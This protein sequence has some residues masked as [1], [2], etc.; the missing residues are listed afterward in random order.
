[1][2]TLNIRKAASTFTHWGRN[3]KPGQNHSVK[4]PRSTSAT[5][6][7]KQ[8][9]ICE[10]ASTDTWEQVW[11]H[12]H[13][14]ARSPLSYLPTST[15]SAADPGCPKSSLM[16]SVWACPSPVYLVS[17]V[18][19]AHTGGVG[20]LTS[21]TDRQSCSWPASKRATATSTLRPA[22]KPAFC[23]TAV[24]AYTGLTTLH[25]ARNSGDTTVAFTRQ[26]PSSCTI[27]APHSQRY[28]Q[29]PKPC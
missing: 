10:H 8:Q 14:Q 2:F 20:S 13:L 23:A 24:P 3:R 18:A 12:S 22:T 1:M 27:A 16:W 4:S 29:S 9:A 15:C 26:I 25:N 19:L 5:D 28:W 6:T 21:L 11:T 17:Q 7:M